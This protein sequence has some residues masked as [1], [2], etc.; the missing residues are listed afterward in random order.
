M[1]RVLVFL[2]SCLVAFAALSE[3]KREIDR[4]IE[5]AFY[6][7][8]VTAADPN[9]RVEVVVPPGLIYDT[10]WPDVY[11]DRLFVGDDG[12]H[13]GYGVGTLVSFDFDGGDARVELERG[14]VPLYIDS[15]I[16]P[17][18][19]GRLANKILVISQPSPEF[20]G[21][22]DGHIV[23]ATDRGKQLGGEIV[24]VLPPT[25]Q[26]TSHLATEIVP[27]PEGSPF[28][29]YIYVIA[30]GNRSM[31][32]IDPDGNCTPFV[33]DLPGFPLGFSFSSDSQQIIIALKVAEANYSNNPEDQGGSFLVTVDSN[34]KVVGEPLVKGLTMPTGLDYAPEEWGPYAGQ[35][36]VA[37]AKNWQ[38][39][40]PRNKNLIG[41]SVLYRIDEEGNK[42]PFVKGIRNIVGVKF[43]K[44]MA[45]MSDIGGDYISGRPLADGAVFKI[46][47]EGE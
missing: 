16:A 38:N 40:T 15:T 2:S 11:Y 5:E 17:A 37:D 47:Y 18:D 44:N 25:A 29:G 45:F 13:F 1:L 21:A 30:S 4:Y 14:R 26:G 31:H 19:F 22:L 41:D 20:E 9:V 3:E 6:L 34:G 23:F 33:M 39:P 28:D 43:H 10:M 8:P 35:L 46:T 42:I 32:K 24:C 12:G 27:G 7:P 36:F